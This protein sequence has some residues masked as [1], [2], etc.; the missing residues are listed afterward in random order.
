MFYLLLFGL[1][2]Q[3]IIILFPS[4][5]NLVIL[6]VVV[7]IIVYLTKK[8]KFLYLILII[9]LGFLLSPRVPIIS[10]GYSN[11]N[12]NVIS[13]KTNYSIVEN[14]EKQR[15]V[16]YDNI[17]PK[18]TYFEAEG[19][20]KEL[21]RIKF[22]NLTEFADYL[23]NNG[24][25]YEFK[26][27]KINKIDLAYD[28]REAIISR[29]VNKDLPSSNF[30]RLLIFS[31]KTDS[32]DFYQLLKDLSIIHLF[33]I[34]GFHINL[35]FAFMSKIVKRPEYDILLL[36]LITP[37]IYLLDFSY[38]S[39]KAFLILL[40]SLLFERYLKLKFDRLS[41][42][43]LVAVLMIVVNPLTIKSYSFL[44]SITAS[45]NIELISKV[46]IKPNYFNYII[47]NILVY[48]GLLPL[49][50][51]LNYE[52]NLLAIIFNLAF[53]LIIS[54]LY[55]LTF[56][57]TLIPPLQ[58][59]YYPLVVGFTNLTEFAYE[60][61]IMLI[62]GKPDLWLIIF[63]YFNYYLLIAKL[64]IMDLS[65]VY[66]L[67]FVQLLILGFQYSKVYILPNAMVSFLNVN[68]GDSILI[69]QP[70]AKTVI[71]VDTGGNRFFEVT[72]TRT[73]PYLKA[74]GIKHLDYV[75]ITHNDFDHNGSLPYLLANYNVKR[76]VDGQ[77]VE[78]IADMNNINF[79]N[80]ETNDNNKSAVF[81]FKI[82][83]TSFL[84][85]G[86]IDDK[87]EKRLVDDFKLSID[88]LKVSHHGSRYGTSESLLESYQPK[89]A[90]ISTSATNPYNHPHPTVLARLESN[91]VKVFRT[92]QDGT[93][94]FVFNQFNFVLPMINWVKHA[95]INQGEINDLLGL[96][97]SKATSR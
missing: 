1:L 60:Y 70:Y 65:R 55:I 21:S 92:D 27:N 25:Y 34:S 37:Y 35:I 5:L 59:L 89:I 50:L 85:T 17:G 9:L 19:E 45:L 47:N 28:Y 51:L 32:L 40:I 10:T 44:L 75:V 63:Y 7:F 6:L 49:I 18:G 93:I 62:M 11:Q 57:V 2:S 4:F 94:E 87:V 54:P 36:L 20:F 96:W 88:V 41:I 23:N 53:G 71:L 12:L 3:V 90:I 83:D 13:V 76:V 8:Y 74:L 52:F 97:L 79:I 72:K 64:E 73:I 16:V 78:T 66:L 80:K 46:K 68:H 33:V 81:Y 67:A 56:I 82:K 26:I 95:I 22:P 69:I 77:T 61:K 38:P 31:D 43:L 42:I 86:D 14:L 15:F 24:V 48:L 91:G 29:L 39:V 84:L 58:L 30:I